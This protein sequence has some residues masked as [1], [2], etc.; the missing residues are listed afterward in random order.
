MAAF[1]CAGERRVLLVQ[2]R[3]RFRQFDSHAVVGSVFALPLIQ[4]QTLPFGC[5]VAQEPPLNERPARTRG[6]LQ[7]STR[8]ESFLRML[9]FSVFQFPIATPAKECPCITLE[10][11]L[12]QMRG[13]RNQ[14]FSWR[15]SC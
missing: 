3:P 13:A 9:P 10:S 8:V 6:D 11:Q 12:L 1:L 14:S 4:L 15:N 2:R 7:V 5:P